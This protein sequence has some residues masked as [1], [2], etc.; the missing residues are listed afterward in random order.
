VPEALLKAVG[1]ALRFDVPED[2]Q[3]VELQRILQ[4]GRPEAI[5]AEVMGVEPG[6]ALHEPLVAVVREAQ[7]AVNRP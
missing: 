6:R 1:A 5:V 3:S 7:E 4:E 2:T